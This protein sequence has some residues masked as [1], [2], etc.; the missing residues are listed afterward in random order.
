MSPILMLRSW[1]CLVWM[2]A[3]SAQD[4]QGLCMCMHVHVT[5]CLEPINTPSSVLHWNPYSDSAHS[6]ECLHPQALSD[7]FCGLVVETV[8]CEPRLGSLVANLSSLI[9]ALAHQH[10]PGFCS[11][12]MRHVDRAVC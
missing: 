8:Q 5:L 6:L 9:I 4:L 2:T 1:W 12:A 10:R 7:L 3:L 11:N